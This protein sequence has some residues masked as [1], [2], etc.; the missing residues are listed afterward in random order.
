MLL[1]LG[2]LPPSV[3]IHLVTPLLLSFNFLSHST[4]L[5]SSPIHYLG[6]SHQSEVL[7]R[8]SHSIFQQGKGVRSLQQWIRVIAVEKPPLLWEV[9]G[10]E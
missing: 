6:S 2:F 10:Q 3:I 1:K 8:Q 5:N 4:R 9:K 7:L